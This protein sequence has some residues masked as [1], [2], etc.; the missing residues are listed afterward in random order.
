[1]N[2]NFVCQCGH[3]EKVH[4]HIN[5]TG[6]RTKPCTCSG[7]YCDICCDY[8]TCPGYKP[9]NLKYLEIQY[10]KKGS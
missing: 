1:M 3:L 5:G 10:S 6:L 9:D 7:K 2:N 8:I 4:C